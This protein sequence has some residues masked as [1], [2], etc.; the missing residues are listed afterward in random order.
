MP[1]RATIFFTVT[2]HL[3]HDQRMQRICG[4]LAAQ[5]Y[6]VVLVG[7]LTAQ[8]TPLRPLNFEQVRLPCRFQ[9][10]KLMYLHFNWLMYRYLQHR[11]RL[12]RSQGQAVALCAIDL[13]TILPC[14]MVSKMLG[15]PR[16]YDAHE[17]FT[18][19]TEVKA[20]PAIARFWHGVEWLAVPR[21]KHGYTVNGFIAD[22]LGRRYGVNY[23]VVRN[24]PL[25]ASTGVPA[26]P[27]LPPLPAGRFL[28]YQ[29]AVN[30][31]RS[32][33]T[34]IP[35]LHSCSLPLVIAG[36]GNFMA[37]LRA[38]IEANG[39]QQ[40][41]WLLGALDPA[42]L[43][44]LTPRAF[45]GLTLFSA[46]GLNQYY[47]LANRFFDYVQAG[48]PQ[49]CVNYP[50]YAAL[51]NQNS[52]ALLIPDTKPETIAEAVN[53]LCAHPLLENALRAAARQ[54]AALWCWENEAPTLIKFWSAVLNR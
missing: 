27:T 38:L 53:K 33:E 16:V 30:E 51:C 23:A 14:L 10:G 2:N 39:L 18:E 45:A 41:V 6:G 49:I 48:I 52:P 13:D 36:E 40:R 17:L 31:G 50:E 26:C 34:L 54:N 20:R 9:Q 24:F 8:A 43:R 1:L 4:T 3:S 11:V 37:Q 25:A 47:S 15:L 29:G 7:R 19:L 12:L 5:G 46:S 28:L 22:E 44:A 42:T 21:F 32:F 35:A